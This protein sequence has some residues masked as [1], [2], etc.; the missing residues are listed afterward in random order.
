MIEMTVIV[1]II[2]VALMSGMAVLILME[3]FVMEIKV[4]YRVFQI[5]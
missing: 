3:I 1:L 5:D 4:L 2:L